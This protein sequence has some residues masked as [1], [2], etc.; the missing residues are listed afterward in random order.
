MIRISADRLEKEFLRILLD[1]GFA[2]DRAG[3]CARVFTQNTLDGVNSHGVN[4]FQR[5]IEQV[6]RGHVVIDAEPHLKHAMGAMEQW[7]GRR[8]PGIL[9]ATFCT[10]RAMQLARETGIG[11][12]ALANTNHWM[13]GGSYGRQAAEQGIAFLG[14]TNTLP[15][16]PVWGARDVRLGNN[17][18]V[19]AVPADKSPI[20]LDM[21]VS[22]FSYGKLESMALQKKNLP[23][24]G[25]Y[26]SNGGL[27]HDPSEIL[28]TSR[29]LP[30]GYWKGSGLAL[31]LDIMAAVF[32]GGLS[33]H[34]IGQLSDETS[35]S[36]VFICFNISGLSNSSLV[37]ETVKGI[38]NDYK[39][40]E[41]ESPDSNIRF[42]GEQVLEIRKQRQK[43]GIPVDEQIWNRI[44]KL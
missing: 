18:I 23:V 19:L 7:D 1:R 22:Q 31:L 10:D 13:R 15:N 4:R 8:G 27:T 37:S 17:P 26:N 20:V 5:F 11:C 35:V 32:A 28:K 43:L 12:V 2:K 39:K 38:I 16:L 21:A 36:Q 30:A 25:G 34:E 42:P 24:P 44:L 14:W 40:S 3:L 9:N 6:E 29:P 41:P 33:T